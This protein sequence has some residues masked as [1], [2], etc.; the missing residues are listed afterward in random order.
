MAKKK[1]QE[2][3]EVL[4]V[5]EKSEEIIHIVGRGESLSGIAEKY[6][7]KVEQIIEDNGIKNPSVVY[8]GQKV[9]VKK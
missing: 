9:V 1:V 6:G 3:M 8:V 5:A 7:V 4:E 2:E